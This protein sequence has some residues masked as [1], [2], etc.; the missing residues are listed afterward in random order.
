MIQSSFNNQWYYHTPTVPNWHLS[1]LK[2]KILKD[3]GVPVEGATGARKSYTISPPAG[4]HEA[5]SMGILCL[6]CNPFAHSY[7]YWVIKCIQLAQDQVHQN[8]FCSH[9]TR[10]IRKLF[11]P[12]KFTRV[13]INR[14]TQCIHGSGPVQAH[15]CDSNRMPHIQFED[16]FSN[17][18]EAFQYFSFQPL[19]EFESFNACPPKKVTLFP[20]DTR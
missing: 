7:V 12:S 18:L 19:P 17:Q 15:P 20:G 3:A 2:E 13:T 14:E 10:Q 1:V 8:I 6:V 16:P 11:Y 4:K 9:S 5:R